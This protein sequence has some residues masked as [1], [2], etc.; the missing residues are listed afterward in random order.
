L[1]VLPRHVRCV[2]LHLLLLAVEVEVACDAVNSLVGLLGCAVERRLGAL[3]AGEELFT[4]NG[5]LGVVRA[6]VVSDE[7]LAGAVQAGERRRASRGGWRWLGQSAGI[8]LADS[9]ALGLVAV[10]SSA[11][12]E[13][14][15][16][17]PS[18][19]GQ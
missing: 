5:N 13:C 16:E 1:N 19:R 17:E 15:P 6:A 18:M 12:V 3:L 2:G 10:D 11:E 7:A 8:G 4:T 9:V 14:A